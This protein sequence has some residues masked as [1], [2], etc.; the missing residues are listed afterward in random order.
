MRIL[1][2]DSSDGSLFCLE[3]TDLLWD[4][5]LFDLGNEYDIY[6]QRK[7]EG[8]FIYNGNE[9]VFAV[10]EI[11]KSRGNELISFAAKN[12]WVDLSNYSEVLNEEELD[13]LISKNKKQQ[14]D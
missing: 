8:L 13:E 14:T 2:K 4:G 10:P 1:L 12:G 11:N 9:F 7:V 5:D 6:S 3:A